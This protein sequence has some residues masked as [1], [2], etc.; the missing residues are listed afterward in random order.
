MLDIQELARYINKRVREHIQFAIRNNPLHFA[1][2]DVAPRDGLVSWDEYHAYFLREKGVPQGFIESHTEG[3]HVPLDRS[4]KGEKTAIVNK[5]NTYT[6]KAINCK[7]IQFSTHRGNDAR[8]G[9]VER[10]SPY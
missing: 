3:N 1:Q 4:A 7:P 2:V 5:Q 6:N 8:Q 9:P 10:G